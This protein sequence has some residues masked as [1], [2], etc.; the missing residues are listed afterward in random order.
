MSAYPP[1]FSVN[2]DVPALTLR[3]KRRPEHVQQNSPRAAGRGRDASYLAPP[4]QNRTC[5]FPAYGSH[6][7]CLTAKRFSGQGWII[8]GLG[9]HSSTSRFIRSQ[10]S[11]AISLRRVRT[12]YQRLAISARNATSARVLFGT[13]W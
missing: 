9:S 7:G 8:R 6:L 3:A 1:I 12:R 10:F 5:S 11:F 13:A 2:A 4:A